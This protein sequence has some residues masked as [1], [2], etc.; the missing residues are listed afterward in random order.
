MFFVV[1]QDQANA[2]RWTLYAA[3][4]RKI[5]DSGESYVRKEGAH[6]GINLFKGNDANTPAY[7][8]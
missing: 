7:E 8:R 6:W 1:Y 5:A 3:N 2:W 4:N